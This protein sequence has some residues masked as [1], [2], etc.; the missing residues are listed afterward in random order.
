M[1]NFAFSTIIIFY[2]YSAFAI[3]QPARA[4]SVPNLPGIDRFLVSSCGNPHGD[5]LMPTHPRQTNED[6]LMPT[7]PVRVIEDVL[8]PT[9]PSR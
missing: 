4:V 9:H 3:N 5:I 2:A 1:K 8:M 6:V 7:H